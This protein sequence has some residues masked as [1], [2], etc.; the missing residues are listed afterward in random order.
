MKSRRSRKQSGFGLKGK[1]KKRKPTSTLPPNMAPF[2]RH[3]EDQFP[4]GRP[5]RCHVGK[6]TSKAFGLKRSHVGRV[7]R[8][9]VKPVWARK[10]TS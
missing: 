10:R 7:A 2:G 6:G 5:V 1:P 8:L 3:L 9:L 4:L